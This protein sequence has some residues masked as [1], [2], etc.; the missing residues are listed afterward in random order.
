MLARS[1]CMAALEPTMVGGL[2]GPSPDAGVSPADGSGRTRRR[3]RMAW[4]TSC[5]SC[6]T[7]NGFSM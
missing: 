6:S 1:D 4:A 7:L 5:S 3:C 2:A